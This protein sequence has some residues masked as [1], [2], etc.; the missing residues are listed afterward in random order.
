MFLKRIRRLKEGKKHKSQQH[1]GSRAV[2]RMRS[3]CVVSRGGPCAGGFGQAINPS[4]PNPG[5]TRLTMFFLAIPGEA[6][7]PS[8]SL[9][10]SARKTNLADF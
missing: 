8:G 6:S 1:F 10:G 4:G 3:V 9:P 2:A 7:F 5:S